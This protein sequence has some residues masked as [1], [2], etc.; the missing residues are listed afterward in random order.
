MTLFISCLLSRT[1][2]SEFDQTNFSVIPSQ[3]T[4]SLSIHC[5][6]LVGHR[7]RLHN[8]S[9]EHLYQLKDLSIKY[10]KLSHLPVGSLA[11]LQRLDNLTIQTFPQPDQPVSLTVEGGS[12]GGETS[13]SDVS[14]I[15]TS[16]LPQVSPISGVSLSLTA[17]SGGSRTG[18][19]A[20]SP[21]SPIS[22]CP[23]TTSRTSPTSAL[24]SAGGSPA[25]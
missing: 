18:N 15:I 4:V 22:T 17:A 6:E 14:R 3:G 23:A 1:I 19:S 9:L 21:A 2:N 10:C 16:T 8:R 13:E 24:A 20:P 12:L 5:A 7:S 25:D 11:G